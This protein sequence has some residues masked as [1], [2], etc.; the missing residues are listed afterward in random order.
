MLRSTPHFLKRK[1]QNCFNPAL[2]MYCNVLTPSSLFVRKGCQIVTW[3]YRILSWVYKPPT[4][5]ETYKSSADHVLRVLM[6]PPAGTYVFGAM[7]VAPHLFLVYLTTLSYQI[8]QHRKISEYWRH[9][10]WVCGKKWAKSNLIAW[11][12]Q[13]DHAT[14]VGTAGGSANMHTYL[15]GRSETCGRHRQGNNLVSLQTDILR[16]LPV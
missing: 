12:E 2:S 4:L 13:G 5:T 7:E 11:K 14:S 15:Q 8:I 10:T 9:G 16:K 6:S 1:D 3:C